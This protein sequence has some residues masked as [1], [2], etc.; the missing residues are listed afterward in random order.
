MSGWSDLPNAAHIDRVLASEKAHSEVWSSAWSVAWED[1]DAMLVAAQNEAWDVVRSTDRR[2]AW[3]A[4]RDVVLG[5]AARGAILALVAYDDCEK[6]LSMPSDQ[7]RV[8][9][10]L[11]E[12]SAAILLI[13]A[14]IAFERIGELE[15]V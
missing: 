8:W 15:M 3:Y 13:P 1:R 6:Y 11:S 4:A 10:I 7:L 14:V 9:A 2:E 12:N 5:D